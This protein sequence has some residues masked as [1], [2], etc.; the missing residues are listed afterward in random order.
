MPIEWKIH[1]DGRGEPSGWEETSDLDADNLY[2]RCFAHLDGEW[3]VEING[4][5]VITGW[6]VP[7]NLLAAKVDA[8]VHARGIL[9]AAV[10]QLNDLAKRMSDDMSGIG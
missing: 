10:D 5:S 1:K 8:L 2:V 7:R 4:K 6:A 3:F 9:Q